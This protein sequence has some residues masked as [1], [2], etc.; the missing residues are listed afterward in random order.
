M[1][2][3]KSCYWHFIKREITA[4]TSFVYASCFAKNVDIKENVS[5]DKTYYGSAI[6]FEVAFLF[7]MKQNAN[8]FLK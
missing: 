5:A 8:L 3:A 7:A 2:S 6:F 4:A 1:Q